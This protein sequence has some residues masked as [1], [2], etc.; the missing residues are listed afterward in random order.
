MNVNKPKVIQT[1]SHATYAFKIHT[2]T[3]HQPYETERNETNPICS[4]NGEQNSNKKASSAYGT[5]YI[6]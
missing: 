5:Y 4:A 3:R 6:L 1:A 2:A